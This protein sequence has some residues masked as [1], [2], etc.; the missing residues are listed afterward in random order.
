MSARPA[1][2]TTGVLDK[3][4][5]AV[6][7]DLLTVASLA[8]LVYAVANVLHEGLGHGGAC[9]LVGGRPRLLTSV[10]FNC[11]LA[12]ASPMAHRLVAAGGTM[13]NLIVGAVAALAYA[14][15]TSSRP[16]TRFFLWL[17]ATLNLLQGLGYF[18]FSGAVGVGDWAAVMAPVQ[19]GWLWRIALVGI[20]GAL[21]WAATS[22]AFAALGAFIGGRAS[23]RYP[24]GNRFALTAYLAGGTLY[25]VA[26]LLNPGGVVLLLVS[27][28]A[29]SFGGASGLAWGPQLLRGT[30]PADATDAPTRVGRD[31]RIIAAAAVAALLFVFLLGPGVVLG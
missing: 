26:G 8:V 5:R 28:A 9:V 2:S 29:A 6:P 16:T 14:R 31:G 27:A 1:F 10:S 18:A 3:P 11:D 15:S 12:G 7:S 25:C 21:Y 19:P 30:G 22:R 24:V 13:V 23:D 4:R 20:G 17:L